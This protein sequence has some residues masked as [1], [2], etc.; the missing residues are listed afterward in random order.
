MTYDKERFIAAQNALTAA[1]TVLAGTGAD[2]D[3]I[4]RLRRT[5]FASTIELGTVGAAVPAAPTPTPAPAAPATAVG[6]PQVVEAAFPNTAVVPQAPV[7]QTVS[8][9][10]GGDDH[11][12]G[13]TINSG[14]HKGKTIAQ[15]VA[16]DP[17][18]ATWASASLRND[19]LRNKLND[20]LATVQGAGV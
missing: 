1:A 10:S 15:A 17:E 18:W 12:A 16:E 2:A 3:A 6:V 9:F 11:G 19:F 20:Y 5:L 8:Q 7:P 13:I 14:K 4:D